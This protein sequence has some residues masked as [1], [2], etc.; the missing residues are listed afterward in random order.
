MGEL[1]MSAFNG[2]VSITFLPRV[3]KWTK[4]R[5]IL[6]ESAS[7]IAAL[8]MRSGSLPNTVTVFG[9]PEMACQVAGGPERIAWFGIQ[10]WG[11]VGDPDLTAYIEGDAVHEIGRCLHQLYLQVSHPEQVDGEFRMFSCKV[12]G[13]FL[14]SDPA[15]EGADLDSRDPQHP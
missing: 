15:A 12:R 7:Q 6:P 4:T 14:G 3:T 10:A 9:E 2:R 1:E 8:M 11:Y 5:N 13:F